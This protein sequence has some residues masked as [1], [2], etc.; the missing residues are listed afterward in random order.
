MIYENL[1]GKTS[2]ICEVIQKHL[3][4]GRFRLHFVLELCLLILISDTLAP[5]CGYC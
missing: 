2:V 5:S 3:P 4:T 1:S